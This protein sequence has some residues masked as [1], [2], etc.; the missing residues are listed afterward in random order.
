MPSIVVEVTLSS[1]IMTPEQLPELL[2]AVSA[3]VPAGGTEGVIISGRLPVW[4]YAALAHYF[5]PR[6]FV[7]TYDPRL[8]GG[9]VVESHTPGVAVGTIVPVED[10]TVSVTF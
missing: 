10:Q 8:S 7:A 1:G 6:P 9:V 3:K 2:N 4:A 5:H